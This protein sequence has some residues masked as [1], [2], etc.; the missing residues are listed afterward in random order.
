MA[1]TVTIT[2]TPAPAVQPYLDHHGR[3]ASSLPGG[4]LSWLGNLRAEGIA[5]FRKQGFPGARVE[6]WRYTNLRP[7][8]KV[9][10]EPAPAG[11]GP[12]AAVSVDLL[13]TVMPAGQP[14]HRL[15]F[16]DGAFRDDLSSIGTLPEGAVVTSLGHALNS[17][18]DL[19]ERHLGRVGVTDSNPF[20][21]L[22]T[23]F[24]ADG[25]VVHLPK[26]VA[27]AEPIEVVFIGT[28]GV[29]EK[30]TMHHPRILVV[31]EAN[32]EATLVEHHLGQGVGTYFANHVTEIVAGEGARL[33]HY[34]VQRESTL[35]FHMATVTADLAK[36]AS[37]DNFVLTMG[38]RLS[39]NEI[40]PV[41]NGTGVECRLSG[42]YMV[43]GQQHCDTTTVID[44]AQPHCTSREVYK[45]VIDGTAK[46][47]FQGKIIVRPDAQKTDGY[48]LNRALLLSD[49]A[50]IDSKPELEIY[51]DDVKCS[52]GATAGELD[53][54]QLFYLR[55]RGIDL[56]SARNLLIAAFLA[57]AIE[58]VRIDT[59]REAFQGMVTGWLKTQRA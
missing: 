41:L 55:A 30:P 27:V 13:P 54:D 52:H 42:A 17:H 53:D 58:E 10:F 37:Y 3:V 39:R 7:L 38:G 8:E 45:G 49:T 31:A 40:K 43:N 12:S 18:A 48:Q 11:G 28:G 22:N 15:V 9:A 57:D 47:V 59:V 29:S 23:A 21:A 46:A 33:H 14:S 56:E 1:K 34:K 20:Q 36:D 44:H 19:L 25:V 26:G 51:A 4:D 24:L 6:A 35:A 50:E 2:D 5:R 32:S 16:V